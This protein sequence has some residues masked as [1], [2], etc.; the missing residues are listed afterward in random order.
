MM[1]S[2][3]HAT[4]YL[5]HHINLLVPRYSSRYGILKY[6]TSLSSIIILVGTSLEVPVYRTT[7]VSVLHHTSSGTVTLLNMVLKVLWV[8]STTVVRAVPPKN[9]STLEI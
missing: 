1:S 2:T 3:R 8:F 7:Q 6:G 5:G 9:R 4:V